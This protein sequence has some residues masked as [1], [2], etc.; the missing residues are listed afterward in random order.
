MAIG[1]VLRRIKISEVRGLAVSKQKK[2]TRARVRSDHNIERL[3]ALVAAD[4]RLTIR[5][6]SVEL[7]INKKTLRQMLHDNLQMR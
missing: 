1:R 3:R 4:R 6:L 2:K 5:M 7:G